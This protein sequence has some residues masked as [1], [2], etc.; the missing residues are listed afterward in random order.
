MATRVFTNK[1]PTA[2]QPPKTLNEWRL[3][4]RQVIERAEIQGDRRVEGLRKAM[5]DG[6]A[7]RHLRMMGIIHP[8]DILREFPSKA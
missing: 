3:L 4:M 1:A 6:N 7:E 8:T 5:A 2:I